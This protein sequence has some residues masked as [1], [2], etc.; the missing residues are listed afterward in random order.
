MT[1]K[2]L[3]LLLLPCALATPRLVPRAPS[4]SKTVIIQMFEWTWDSVASECTNFIGP[5]GYGFVQGDNPPLTLTVSLTF[6]V[7]SPPAE[8]VTGSAWWTDYQPVSYTLT[9]KRG[10]RSQFAKYA[11]CQLLTQ[12]FLILSIRQHGNDL[13]YCRRERYCR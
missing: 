2:S 12:V 8:H 9:S 4:G 7:V 13:S 6:I 10:S 3:L 1:F 5:A 11:L